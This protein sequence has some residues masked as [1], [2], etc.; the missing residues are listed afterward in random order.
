MLIGTCNQFP[1]S[2]DMQLQ[3]GWVHFPSPS[4]RNKHLPY[5]LR[6]IIGF[7]IPVLSEQKKNT[8]NSA[9][10]SLASLKC[11]DKPFVPPILLAYLLVPEMFLSPRLQQKPAQFEKQEHDYI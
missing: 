11:K 2:L 9:K 3:E 8:K 5:P 4:A 6:C 10:L 1:G 7:S